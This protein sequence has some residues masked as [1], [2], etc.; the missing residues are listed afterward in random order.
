MPP[1][2]EPFY[3]LHAVSRFRQEAREE[4]DCFICDNVVYAPEH[5]DFDSLS[6]PGYLEQY[7]SGDVWFEVLFGFRASGHFHTY[8]AILEFL[9]APTTPREGRNAKS[10]GDRGEQAVLVSVPQEVEN[11]QGVILR[12][13]PSVIR[14]NGLN[15]SNSVGQNTL[16]QALEVVVA[17]LTGIDEDGEGGL[18]IRLVGLQERQL[19][20][21]VIQGGAEVVDNVANYNRQ[22]LGWRRLR[23]EL[24]D[25]VIDVLTIEVTDRSIG[26]VLD[27][28]FGFPLEFFKVSTRPLNLEPRTGDVRHAVYSGLP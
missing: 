11:P 28:A 24:V 4:W 23:R 19:P 8:C 1:L 25:I 26:V 21:N 27:E 6:E 5:V 3:S 12:S 13:V 15:G 22:A 18:L 14:L 7:L 16:G 9:D 20:S 17:G 2:D 10:G